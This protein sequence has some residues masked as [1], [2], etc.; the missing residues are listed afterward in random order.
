M[1]EILY[2][3]IK[4]LVEQ[5]LISVFVHNENVHVNEIFSKVF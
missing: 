1:D 2:V 5:Q 3:S 4:L